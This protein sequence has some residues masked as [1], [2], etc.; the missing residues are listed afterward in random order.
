M[1]DF[2]NKC[3]PCTIWD[4]L[5]LKEICYFLR[6]ELSILYFILEAAPPFM[7]KPSDNYNFM[8]YPTQNSPAKLLQNLNSQ[9]PWELIS[10]YYYLGISYA[11]I[12]IR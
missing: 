6:N 4:I 5:L 12:D 9:T 7:I 2:L 11:L 8:R 1:M 3:V 10:N